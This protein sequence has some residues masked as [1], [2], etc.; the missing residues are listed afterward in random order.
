LKRNKRP[1]VVGFGFGN[2]SDF[3]ASGVKCSKTGLEFW[4][5]RKERIF[6]NTPGRHNIYNAL[7]AIAV[8]RILGMSYR[9]IALR[10]AKF[11]FP[12]G[13]LKLTKAGGVTFLD[14]TYNSNPL[15]LKEALATLADFSVKGRKVFI[16]GDMRELGSRQKYFHAQAGR[17]AAA[18]CDVLISVG[19][20][21]RLAADAARRAGLRVK[22][23]F[24][25]RDS[26]Q[27][28]KVIFKKVIPD[29]RD[30]ILVK[31][32]RAMQMEEVFKS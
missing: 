11:D 23:I 17:D 13:R 10:L 16:M 5:N 14:D 6:L 15:S 3:Q 32:S 18:V 31:G 24:I 4:V 12:E 22:D 26:R 7:I 19:E 27:A 1:F 25:C 28:R 21:S 20:L 30:I 8:A 2:H 9:D 29:S